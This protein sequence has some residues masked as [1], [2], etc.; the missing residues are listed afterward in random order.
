[1]PGSSWTVVKFNKENS[2][3]AVPTAWI[4]NN[5]CYWPSFQQDKV[6]AAIRKNEEPD[7][8]WPS[9]GI[10]IFRN[11][12]YNDY[13]TAREKCKK[14]ENTSDLNS[15]MSGEEKKKRKIRKKQFFSSSSEDE[16]RYNFV[17][18]PPSLKDNYGQ[19]EVRENTDEEV[20]ITQDARSNTSR[21]SCSGE[22]FQHNLSLKKLE[23]IKAIDKQVAAQ[24]DN[25][26]EVNCVN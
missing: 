23:R 9:Y 14:A 2:V 24:Q 22:S 6:I 18:T 20:A 8:H 16:C 5:R 25:N 15:E 4:N 13:I 17:P 10:T 1:M 3:E 21:S 26:F 11:S 7:I 12:T 19:D